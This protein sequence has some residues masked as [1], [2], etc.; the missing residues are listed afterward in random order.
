MV[1]RNWLHKNT[2]TSSTGNWIGALTLTNTEIYKVDVSD[3]FSSID[4]GDFCGLGITKKV[5]ESLMYIGL[6]LEYITN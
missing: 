2:W 6:L 4:A 1:G 5:N 3:V